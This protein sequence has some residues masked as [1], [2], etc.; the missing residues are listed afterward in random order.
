MSIKRTLVPGLVVMLLSFGAGANAA[1]ILGE[2]LYYT[3][4]DV[5]VESLPVSSG[6]VSELGLYDAAFARVFYIMNDEPVGTVVTFD[7][8]DYGFLRGR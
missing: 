4:G 6:F 7:P 3:G 5:T 1:P 2:Q 8:A